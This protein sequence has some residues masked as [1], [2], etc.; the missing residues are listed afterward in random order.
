[1]DSNRESNW[2]K[3]KSDFLRANRC[4]ASQFEAAYIRFAE[5]NPDTQD[6]QRFARKYGIT[7]I[8]DPDIPETT[9][10]VLAVTISAMK[11][12]AKTFGEAETAVRRI[13]A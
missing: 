10:A 3:Y 2:R 7:I 8:S 12:M 11:V 6:Y 13:L 5:G 9:R 1:M 4:T